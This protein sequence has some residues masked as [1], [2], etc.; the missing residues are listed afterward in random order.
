MERGRT[1]IL[2]RRRGGRRGGRSNF[3]HWT[4]ALRIAGHAKLLRITFS[5]AMGHS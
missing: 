2:L 3:S 4:T 1:H 5:G